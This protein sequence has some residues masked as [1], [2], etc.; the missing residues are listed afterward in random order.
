M[1]LKCIQKLHDCL[2]AE[3]PEILI[4]DSLREKAVKPILR[5]L[6]LS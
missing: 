3:S 2:Q 5:M 6:E 4:E 1:R